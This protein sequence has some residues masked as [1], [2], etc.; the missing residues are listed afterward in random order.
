M[1]A[2][3]GTTNLLLGIM[4]VVSVLEALLLIGV[5]VA[6]FMAYRR[7]MTLVET[8]RRAAGRAGDGARQR[9]S[10]RC[11]GGERD[12][13]RETERVDHAIRTTID[14]VDDTA[15]RVRSN[16]RA[17]TSRVVGFVRGARRRDRDDAA[18]RGMR[19][20]NASGGPEGPHY[21]GCELQGGVMADGYDRFDNEG[22]GGG[23]FVMGLLT[24]TVLGAGLGMLFAPKAGCRA[25]Q[26]ARRAGRQPR[27][28]GVGRLS[29]R[30]RDGRR[31]GRE[32][33]RGVRQGARAPST[34]AP[35]RRSATSAKRPAADTGMGG[36]TN[37]RLVQRHEVRRSSP[38]PTVNQPG[39]GTPGGTRRS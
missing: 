19:D 32:G 1:E 13:E 18:S 22:G 27:Q 3:L 38:G 35:T 20:S 24:G 26:P 29:Q 4:A 21:V 15:D 10:R 17:K 2:N 8:A 14:R 37:A 7:V 33:P 11:E 9:H 5:G 30:E 12:G 25:A 16:V 34:A 6:G 31:V 36:G 28:H 23:S 39:S